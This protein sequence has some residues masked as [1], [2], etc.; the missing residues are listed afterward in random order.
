VANGSGEL[1][2]KGSGCGGE[3]SIDFQTQR[4]ASAV[5]QRI[6]GALVL[7]GFIPYTCRDIGF[8]LNGTAGYTGG[9]PGVYLLIVVVMVVA[10]ACLVAAF[11]GSRVQRNVPVCY[12]ALVFCALASVCFFLVAASADL[13]WAT[14]LACV[15]TS[16]VL[17]TI[18]ILMWVT[19]VG[20]CRNN[21]VQAMRSF[22]LMRLGWALGPL[23]GCVLTLATVRP[24][25]VNV[26]LLCVHAA[27]C[28]LALY[29]T[30]ALVLPESVLTEALAIMPQRYRKPFKE[31]CQ[32]VSN[33]YGLTERE[34]EVM[35]LFAKGRDSAYIQQTLSLSKSTV[36]THRQHIYVKLGVHSQQE[37]LN[38]LYELEAPAQIDT[39]AGA[40]L[41]A[42]G[43]AA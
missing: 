11:L 26:T 30:Y 7:I 6:S 16:G 43:A 1:S 17:S 22:A 23:L 37:L 41:P 32:M 31:R 2:F 21:H 33:R 42:G 40:S 5:V 27:L 18:H 15:A 9:S 8:A 3:P 35:A 39:S 19:T 13:P 14:G 29:A 25:S 12:R 24:G 10:S 36:S 20:I 28:V 38:L 34:A 4:R